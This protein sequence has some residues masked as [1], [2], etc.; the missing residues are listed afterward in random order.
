MGWMGTYLQDLRYAARS[1]MKSRAFTAVAAITLTIGIGANT[2]IFSV[3][4]SVL[5]RPLPF[6][7]PSQL[8]RLY[9]TEAAPGHYPFAPP[10]FIDW[11][12]QNRTFQDMALF[13]WSGDMNI[14]G[15]GRPDHVNAV[16][17]E[18]NFFQLLG[19]QPMM[20][21]TW[22]PGEDQ[23][24]KDHVAVLS[25]GLW[26]EHFAGDPG[27]V[28]RN[29]SLN[30]E[31]Y[32]VV[33]VM[34][35]SFRFPFQ[36]QM[37]V[38]LD[39]DPKSLGERGSHWANAVG[40]L[41]PGVSLETARADLKVISGRLEKTYPNSNDKVGSA[42]VPLRDDLVG[43][44]RGALL[45][46]LSA[47]GLV[48]LIACAN[49]ANL[50]LS[51]AVA[52]QKEM[53][54]RSALGAAR[55]RLVRQ[56]LTES[57]LLSLFGGVLGLVV[58]WILIVLA[59]Q[60]KSLAL[61]R[62]N[63]L[64]LN[65]EVLAFTFVLAV[66]T[67]VLFGLAPALRLSRPDLHEE[68][69]G[70]AG[71]LISPGKRRRFTSDL[72]V[73]GEMALSLL[74]L[75]SAGLLLKDFARMRT[76]DIG[77]RTEGVFTAA[78]RLP[79]NQYKE[80]ARQRQFAQDFLEKASGIGSVDA[81]AIT[82]HL[83]LEGGSN[84][85]VK[86][87]GQ[88]NQMSDLLVEYHTITP[89][90]FRV[91]GIR[92]L[93]GRVFG[94]D[95][96]ARAT[97]MDARF[98]RLPK[99]EHLPP[100][101]RNA[102]IYPVVINETMA[103][104]FWPNRSPLGQLFSQGS[105]T[106]P[107]KQV[108][109]VVSDVREWGLTHKPVPEAYDAFTGNDRFFLVLHTSRPPASLAPGVRRILAQ[110]DASL[111][112]FS[113]RSMD[114]VIAENAQGQQFLSLLVGS[115]AGLAMLLAAVGIYGVLSYAVTERTREIG[116]RLSLGAT[117]GRVLRQII[118]EGMRLAVAG[119]AVGAVAAVAAGR[120]LASLLH[121]VKPGDPWIFALTAGCLALVA[122]LACYIPARRAARLDPMT[123]LRYE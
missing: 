105:D 73:A 46:M 26:R 74:L 112:L 101:E 16:P 80:A 25:Y 85:Y 19:V 99:G 88:T 86:L 97:D 54:V 77:V 12:A 1:L 65:F 18:A 37:W 9:E 102:M 50:L 82:S 110:A 90:Y 42:A 60:A 109:G 8:V 59:G 24:G 36:T 64:Q 2:A 43:D 72:L 95:D 66:V 122:L 119:F 118:L 30:S 94:P 58:A 123:A 75:V 84:Y 49:V 117:R 22:L 107:W 63:I 52:R 3:I 69:K 70:G 81:A 4:D 28:G 14:S 56:L 39:M 108:I 7:D 87:R 48:L 21:R 79:E 111:P 32:T 98:E 121:E 57:L 103:H 29:I 40:R 93:E 91:M 38:P 31:K 115:F 68:L 45:M 96:L 20:G 114:Q 27:M 23:K 76:L 41:K 6:R 55:G 71:S 17:T 116:I 83:P 15:Q 47:V 11:K 78:V 62:F 106:G 5:L 104:D 120:M 92:L 61:P 51:R 100:E 10:D 33:G 35:A 89:S 34:P 13:G 67:G 44:S 113:V 53:A